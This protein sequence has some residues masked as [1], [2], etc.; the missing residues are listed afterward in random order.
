METLYIFTDGEIR[1]KNN[2]MYLV[3]KSKEKK[4]M[5]VPLKNVSSIMI[6]SEV[7]INKKFLEML[8]KEEI[9][10]HFFGYYGNYLGT[11][12]PREKNKTGKTLLLQFEH[13]NDMEKRILIAKEILKAAVHNMLKVLRGFKELVYDEILYIEKIKSTLDKQRNIPALMAIEG[14]IRK[15]YYKAFG[16]IV[17]KKD[18]RFEERKRKPPKDEINALISYGNTI[19]Y[20]IVLSEIYKTSLEPQISFLHE[21]KNKKFS[22]QLDIS[23]I[24]K[25]IIVDKVILYL[26]NNKIVQKSDFE[27]TNGGIYLSKEGKKK[28]VLELEKRLEKTVEI[29]PNQKVSFKTVILHEC[30]KL[31]R[32]LKG[33]ENYRG[34]RDRG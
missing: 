20:N 34:F 25:P 9:P 5:I 21:P 6:F 8:Y 26:V 22:L 32:H 19:L 24:F 33:E 29:Y 11:F 18:F 17:G 4:P 2:A 12:Y 14:N 30:Y 31:I 15:K 7:S 28:F 23:E 10:L 27:P 3:P 1:K 13:Y 16:K